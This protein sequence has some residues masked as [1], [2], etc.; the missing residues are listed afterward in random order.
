MVLEEKI[1]FTEAEDA[2]RFVAYLRK[3]GCPC[4][5]AV[6]GVASMEEILIGR[7]DEIIAWLP[8]ER[9][10]CEEEGS[11]KEATW[12]RVMEENYRLAREII[13]GLLEGK[14]VGDTIFTGEEM[15][16]EFKALIESINDQQAAERLRA[17]KTARALAFA[18][19]EENDVVKRDGMQYHLTRIVAP[20]D[21]TT[22]FNIDEMPFFDLEKTG[23][24]SR[25]LLYR[26][27][28]IHIVTA[29]PLIHIACD[30]EEVLDFL[31]E[32][33]VPDEA[34]EAISED[35]AGKALIVSAILQEVEKRKSTSV[36]ELA[37]Y[38]NRMEVGGPDSPLL[39][40]IQV[41][42]E[43]V[44]SMV[45]ELL[46]RDVLSGNEQKVRMAG[47]KRRR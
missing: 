7:L 3:A 33:S 6:Q 38:L 1:L 17:G 47:E 5:K 20:D 30:P 39:T 9:S 14:A 16:D 18:L 25:E 2:A 10:R 43:T 28:Q 35:L 34:L 32:L 46:K 23:G 29:D 19:L 22:S 37:E 15:V 40:R 44:A 36:A 45:G 21:L 31:D 42:R 13:A 26:F 8:G 12:F 4:Q 11:E 24:L 27:D 41:K